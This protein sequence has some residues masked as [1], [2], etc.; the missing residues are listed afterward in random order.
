MGI[1]YR[2][3]QFRQLIQAP[4]LSAAAWAEVEE[5]LKPAELA[6]FRRFG[7]GDRQHGYAVISTLREAGH[8]EEALLV[9]ALLHDVGKT[10]LRVRL[11][12]RVVGALGEQFFPEKAAAWGRGE[13]RGWRRPFVIRACHPAWS[14]EMAAGAGSAELAVRLMRHHQDKAPAGLDE[15]AAELVRALQRADGAH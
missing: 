9:A 6:L 10:R 15:E 5:L 13:A 8:E 7:A 14:A 1:G 3:R 11:W 12:E 2:V 4:P